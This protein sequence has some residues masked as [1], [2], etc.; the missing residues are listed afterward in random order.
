MF[1]YTTPFIDKTAHFLCLQYIHVK[2]PNRV[3][4]LHNDMLLRHTIWA[5][6]IVPKSDKF[7]LA[8]SYNHR[9]QK[10]MSMLNIRSMAGFAFGGGLNLK[11]FRLGFA[12]SQYTKSNFTYQASLSLDMGELVK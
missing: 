11:K 5:I 8:V 12:M 10:E 9:R 4:Y 6:E 2:T 3:M 1:I 7:Y